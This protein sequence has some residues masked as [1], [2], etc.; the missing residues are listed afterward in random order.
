MCTI[1][2]KQTKLEFVTIYVTFY[3]SALTTITTLKYRTL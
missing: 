3:T 2:F 1:T